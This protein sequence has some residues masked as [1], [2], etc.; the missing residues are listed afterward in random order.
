MDDVQAL[1]EKIRKN[2]LAEAEQKLADETFQQLRRTPHIGRMADADGKA[3]VVGAN[4]VCMEMYLKFCN[5]RVDRANYI[6]DG[7][8]LSCLCGS[9][10]AEL[11]IGKNINELLRIKPSDVLKRVQRSGEGVE[12]Q[13]LLAVEALH[14]A[15]ENYWIRRHGKGALRQLSRK[16]RFIA[17]GRSTSYM[18]YSH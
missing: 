18:Q 1:I 17:V 11:A 8:G 15:A 6:S 2:I 13:A 4:T 14:K 5:G 9:F 3:S 12:R 10:A 16:P 7:D